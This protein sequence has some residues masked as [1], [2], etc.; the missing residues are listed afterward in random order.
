MH[1]CELKGDKPRRDDQALQ[2]SGDLCL[3]GGSGMRNYLVRR[4]TA[5]P[6]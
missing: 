3:S 2:L 5:Y 6:Y 1:R 4:F